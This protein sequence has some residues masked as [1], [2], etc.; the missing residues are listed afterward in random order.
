MHVDEG[1]LEE[2]FNLQEKWQI[3]NLEIIRIIKFGYLKI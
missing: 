1:F 2:I 3:L